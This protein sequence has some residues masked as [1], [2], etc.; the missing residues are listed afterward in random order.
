LAT[1][2]TVSTGVQYMY[3]AAV[4]RRGRIK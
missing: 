1:L 3:A 4:A 2:L